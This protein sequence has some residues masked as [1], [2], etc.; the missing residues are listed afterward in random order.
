MYD[1]D[2]TEDPFDTTLDSE[3]ALRV[4]YILHFASGQGMEIPRYD[5]QYLK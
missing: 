3:N 4:S 1:I 2:W 5:C